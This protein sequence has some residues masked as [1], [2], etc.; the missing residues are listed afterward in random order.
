MSID[1]ATTNAA[2][3]ANLVRQAVE[4]NKQL[5]K[6]PPMMS[7]F[8]W[9][10]ILFLYTAFWGVRNI[11]RPFLRIIWNIFCQNVAKH[12]VILNFGTL[13]ASNIIESNNSKF[14]DNEV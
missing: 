5:A 11:L 1:P 12:A 13:F 9:P 8:M 3:F 7:M 10:A 6:M 14:Y 4:R 2:V